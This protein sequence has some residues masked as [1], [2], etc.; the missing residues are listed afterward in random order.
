[1]VI[2]R[3]DR[4]AASR[5]VGYVTGTADPAALREL[6]AERLPSCMVPAAVV[7]VEALPRTI[8]RQARHPRPARPGIPGQ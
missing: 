6:V 2:A 3:E 1:V 8:Q 4:P 5:L 7:A